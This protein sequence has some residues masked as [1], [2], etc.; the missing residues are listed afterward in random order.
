VS[1]DPVDGNVGYIIKLEK[2]KTQLGYDSVKIPNKGEPIGAVHHL[3][4]PDFPPQGNKQSTYSLFSSKKTFINKSVTFDYMY[5][6]EFVHDFEEEKCMTSQPDFLCSRVNLSPTQLQITER[7][8]YTIFVML[9][10]CV[11][12]ATGMFSVL[13]FVTKHAPGMY[14]K[15]KECCERRC[16]IFRRRKESTI[17]HP[18]ANP[19]IELPQ[20]GRRRNSWGES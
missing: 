9:T 17:S 14:A 18:Q 4:T 15:M 5:W 16:A 20:D 7:P 6:T 11:T 2:Y 13:K 1:A 19:T 12:A 3:R 10:L 8:T